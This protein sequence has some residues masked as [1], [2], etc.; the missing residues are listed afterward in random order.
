MD[1]GLFLECAGRAARPDRTPAPGVPDGGC[2]ELGRGVPHVSRRR[3]FPLAATS[4]PEMD[5]L[6]NPKRRRVYG[7]PVG[8]S[9]TP[10]AADFCQCRGKIAAALQIV[11]SA[12]AG[13]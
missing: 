2:R 8:A 12:C 11:R 1:S 3:R 9:I 7:V 6:T 13:S 4:L 10:G 5:A